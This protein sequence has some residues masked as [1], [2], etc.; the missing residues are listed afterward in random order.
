MI[1]ERR[2]GTRRMGQGCSGANLRGAVS[3]NG[4]GGEIVHGALAAPK[5]TVR[6]PPRQTSRR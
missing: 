2:W 4:A 5:V 3:V 1:H 6:K